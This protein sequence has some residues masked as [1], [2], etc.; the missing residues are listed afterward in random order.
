[1]AGISNFLRSLGWRKSSIA[2][3][4]TPVAYQSIRISTACFAVGL[5]ADLTMSRRLFLVKNAL[6][7]CGTPLEV[8]ISLLYWGLRAVCD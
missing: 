4:M 2:S 1:M 6:S 5:L 7:V 8:L 3:R